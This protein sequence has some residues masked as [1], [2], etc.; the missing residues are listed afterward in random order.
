MPTHYLHNILIWLDVISF[1]GFRQI[2][3]LAELG[4]NTPLMVT[5]QFM[6]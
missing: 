5:G 4:K 1:N 2:V 6:A 3:T